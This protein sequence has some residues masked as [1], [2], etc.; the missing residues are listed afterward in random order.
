MRL[1]FS[2][3]HSGFTLVELVLSLTIFGIL[4]VMIL[5]VYFQTTNTSRKLNATRQLS[6]TARQIVDRLSEDITRHG[7]LPGSSM[8]PSHAYPLYN[9]HS[10]TS[11]GGQILAIGSS[12]SLLHAYIYG[13]RTDL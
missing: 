4:S 12:G 8:I 1:S 10:Y 11:S 13:T 9:T 3:S 2:H 5:Q 7:I 6:D